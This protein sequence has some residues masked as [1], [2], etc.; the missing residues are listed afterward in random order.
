MFEGETRLLKDV[1]QSAFCQC[2]MHR[3]HG[4]VDV[5]AMP[6][7]E[8]DVTALLPQLHESR[9]FRRQHYALARN[10]R[11]FWSQAGSPRNFNK[12]PEWLLCRGL[13][14]GIAPSFEKKL[15]RLSQIG[16]CGLNVR[17]LRSDAQFRTSSDVEIVLFGNQRGIAVRHESMVADELRPAQQRYLN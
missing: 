7:L 12:R 15:N 17:P 8:R 2:R 9:A 3:H 5:F 1:S 16:P 11:K 4:S 10:T 6:L 13:L 14:P